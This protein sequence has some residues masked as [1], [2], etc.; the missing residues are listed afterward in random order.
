MPNVVKC[1]SIAVLIVHRFAL[2][3]PPP[4]LRLL[5]RNRS[6][7]WLFVVLE[8]LCFCFCFCYCASHDIDIFMTQPIEK[9][10]KSPWH[11]NRMEHIIDLIDPK[12]EFNPI[13]IAKC[14]EIHQNHLH[15]ARIIEMDW[16]DTKARF[17]KLAEK[18][19]WGKNES[20]NEHDFRITANHFISA[21][22]FA[23]ICCRFHSCWLING[24]P[25]DFYIFCAIHFHCTL[26]H[27]GSSRSF[28]FFSSAWHGYDESSKWS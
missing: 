28:L 17:W 27:S 11:H 2:F 22:S 1:F 6:R 16:L 9:N 19:W 20:A 3:V 13:R 7:S 8:W 23:S 18:K 21:F 15:I 24:T 10:H 4:C 26:S 12:A 25:I 5:F 14:I